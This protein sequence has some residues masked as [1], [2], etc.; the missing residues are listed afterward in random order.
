MKRLSNFENPIKKVLFLG[1]DERK[2][3][4][5]NSLIDHGCN[6]DHSSEEVNGMDGYDFVVS[7][8]YKHILKKKCIDAFNCPIFNLH[9]SYLPFNRGAHPNFWSF[10]DG[11]PSGVTIHLI[12][13]GVDTGPIVCQKYVNFNRTEDT[14]SKTYS[15]LMKEIE[16]FYLENLQLFLTDNWSSQKQKGQGSYHTVKDLPKNFSGWSSNIS[17]EIKKLKKE[18]LKYE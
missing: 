14:F 7:F 6:V 5:I 12:D 15:V 3:E 11:T 10:Y 13:S 1:Y 18:G 4:I 17:K 9:I 16:N 2:T 8:G